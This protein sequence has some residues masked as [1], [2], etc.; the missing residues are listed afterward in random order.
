MSIDRAAAE[1]DPVARIS[2]SSFTLP[3][4]IRRSWPKSIRR[5]ALGYETISHQAFVHEI[6]AAGRPRDLGDLPGVGA[7][8]R[9]EI[10]VDQPLQRLCF[11]RRSALA[12]NV[13]DIHILAGR[14]NELELTDADLLRAG[15]RARRRDL[16]PIG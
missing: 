5:L 15:R 12:Q 11:E 4:P 3:G 8:P 13:A 1:I 2:S 6:L 9:R 16:P 14:L 10:G 7:Q